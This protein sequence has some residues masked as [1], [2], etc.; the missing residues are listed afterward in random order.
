[1][2]IEAELF[3]NV[4]DTYPVLSPILERFD[5]GPTAAAEFNRLS[6]HLLPSS[7]LPMS[8]LSR[9]PALADIL[10]RASWRS[11]VAHLINADPDCS[12]AA[13]VTALIQ[14]QTEVGG[15]SSGAA[16]AALADASTASGQSDASSYGSVRDQ[17]IGDALRETEAVEALAAAA[18]QSGIERVETMMQSGSTLLTRAE[19]LQESWL[20]NKHST[21]AFCS[22]DQPY[23]CPYIAGVLTE[24]KDTGEVP[25]RLASYVFPSSE[26]ATLRTRTWSKLRL[27]EQALEIRRLQYG[28]A[29]APVKSAE[30]YVV[31]SCLRVLREHGARQFFALNL[32][33]APTTGYAFTDGVDLMLTGLEFA[34]AL[35]RAEAAEW[36]AF[37]SSQFKTNWL[38]E[39][40][41]YYH[42]KLRSG[43]P[44]APEARLSEYLPLGNSFFVNINARL[45]RAKPVAD[46]RMAFPSLFAADT[47]SLPG[48]SGAAL[49]KNPKKE[50]G[51]DKDKDKGD[52]RPFFDPNLSGP[53]SKSKLA[54]SLSPTELWLGGV[55]FKLDQIAQHYKMSNP[56]HLCWPVLL[57][58]KKGDAA[59]E[60]CPD[61][62]THGDLKQAVHKR[63]QNFDLD[64]IYKNFTRAA[65]AA[66]NKNADWEKP[67]KKR[68]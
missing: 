20:H 63:P 26:L 67:G 57:T 23:L 27:M 25:A 51:N 40:G 22:L 46:F 45:E 42:S 21:L 1:M 48:T 65:T 15:S 2:N 14:T 54:Q 6:A 41:A 19:F 32:S 44:D 61:H 4:G 60:L 55:V 30:M 62:A 31:E 49:I 17:S 38:D 39:G 3:L 66:E 11:T 24:D 47:V 59:L 13:F 50:K 68:K 58:K 35:P 36:K 29:Y 37:L 56:H 53:G 28:T 33:L 12:G 18:T 5:S 10:G 52:K 43:R 34:N 16:P 7:L 9:L 64:Y 8:N